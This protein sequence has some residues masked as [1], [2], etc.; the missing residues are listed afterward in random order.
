MAEFTFYEQQQMIA[1]LTDQQKN[2]FMAQYAAE[3]KDRTTLLLVSIFL[4]KLGV[5]RFMMDD[6][7]MGLVKLFTLGGCL[8]LWIMDIITI[9]DRVDTWNRLKAQQII[10]NLQQS[11]P[12]VPAA[13]QQPV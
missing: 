3:R 1:G 13:P 4:G 10:A 6:V 8:V 7:G 5:D 12:S 9:T 2:M 11:A